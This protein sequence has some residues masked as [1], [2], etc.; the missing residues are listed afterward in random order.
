M[1]KL[2]LADIADLPRLRARAGRVPGPGHRAQGPPAGPRRPDRDVRVREPRHHP[3]PDPGDGPGREDH[4]RRGHRGRA[5]AP[6]TRSSP[7]PVTC[8]PRCSSSS[9]PRRELREWL[10]K[11][12]G[13]ETGRRAAR[14][15][16]RRSPV[17]CIVDPDHERQL[18]REETTASVH[19][20]GW[21]L[22]PDQIDAFAAGPGRARRHP[23]RLRALHR[24]LADE[25]RAELLADLAGLTVD[26]GGGRP[27]ASVWTSRRGGGDTR[28]F[29]RTAPR[30]GG[31]ELPR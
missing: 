8:P 13:I 14:R 23:S 28:P 25:T 1:A 5:A 6:T 7:T 10:P 21:A 26:R 17:A 27:G 18:T 22:T 15:P 31:A 19:Y 12:V 2:T 16:R 24:V 30:S 29:V 4:L 20:V 9:P 3:V 11:L